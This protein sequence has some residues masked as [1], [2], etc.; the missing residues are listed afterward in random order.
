MRQSCGMTWLFP[1]EKALLKRFANIAIDS[2]R[3]LGFATKAAGR[4]TA[5]TSAHTGTLSC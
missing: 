5:W 3:N 4:E 2:E 1:G